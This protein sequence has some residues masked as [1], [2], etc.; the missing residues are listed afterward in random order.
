M[1]LR[2]YEG[3]NCFVC[4]KANPFGLKLRFRLEEGMIKSEFTPKDHHQ[5]Y[6]GIVH[7]GILSAILDDAMANCLY[8]RGV[9]PFTGKL[10]IRF[11]RPIKVGTKLLVFSKL[12]IERKN[13]ARATSWLQTENGEIMVEADGLYVC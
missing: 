2:E 7:G 13:Y 4:G 11:R 6:D 8:L 12:A 1:G 10:E 5:G 3:E 9:K